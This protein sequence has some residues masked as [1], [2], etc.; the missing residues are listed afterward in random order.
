MRRL[1]IG[2]V[3]AV[4]CLAGAAPAAEPKE[5]TPAQRA[6]RVN[7]VF[8]AMKAGTHGE[9]APRFDWQDVPVLLQHAHS[10]TPLK[11]VPVVGFVRAKNNPLTEGM[12]ALYYVEVVRRSYDAFS[13]R[14]L[15]TNIQP[16]C[17]ND[18]EGAKA[19]E[20][21]QADLAVLYTNWWAQVKD[22][23][24]KAGAQV[25]PLKGTKFIWQH[26]MC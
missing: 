2:S 21:P 23:A 24:P 22:A 15:F 8:D 5:E 26:N 9:L 6:E 11:S 1:W 16:I 3:V 17:W 19:P 12:M 4:A 20:G 7:A 10:T 14:L 25:N 18:A 13:D